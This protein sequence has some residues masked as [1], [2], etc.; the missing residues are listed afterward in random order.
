M[1]EVRKPLEQL[2]QKV[3]EGMKT[4]HFPICEKYDDHNPNPNKSIRKTSS[5]SLEE[6]SGEV[7]EDV[8]QEVAR[9]HG[10]GTTSTR[11]GGTN[12]PPSHAT[13]T[14]TSTAGA[15]ETQIPSPVCRNTFGT[16]VAGSVYQGTLPIY[17]YTRSHI[18]N[19]PRFH[20]TRR[21]EWR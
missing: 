7:P 20:T 12:I 19:G 4:V 21:T 10:V 13:V 14:S 18:T 2:A 5:N 9:E 3:A 6:E 1:E 17:S 11:L 15:D 16:P 8:R